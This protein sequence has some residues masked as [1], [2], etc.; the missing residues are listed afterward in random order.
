[1]LPH[2]VVVVVVVVIVVVVVVVVSSGCN[3]RGCRC[4]R[5]LRR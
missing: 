5:A 2:S 4:D 3:R 1:M